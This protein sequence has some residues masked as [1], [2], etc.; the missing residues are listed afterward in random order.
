M[1]G[2]LNKVFDMN[3]R[4]L[5]RLDK[6]AHQIDSLS[7]DVAKLSDEQ[8][9]EKTAEFKGRYEKGESLDDLLVEVFAVV[10]EASK[11]VLGLYPYKVQLM[12]AL[13]YMKGTSPK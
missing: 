10:R 5:K 2:L 3:K 9:R 11:R 6:M 4:Q 1:L 7:G 13:P 12:G 8:L